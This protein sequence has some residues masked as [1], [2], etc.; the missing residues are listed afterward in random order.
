VNE[1]FILHW[2]PTRRPEFEAQNP[3][4]RRLTQEV[5][6]VAWITGGDQAMEMVARVAAMQMQMQMQMA[7]ARGGGQHQY[8]P[9]GPAQQQMSMMTQQPG[10]YPYYANPYA[11]GGAG[12]AGAPPM[13]GSAPMYGSQQGAP[14]MYGSQP[15][16]PPQQQQMYYAQQPGGALQVPPQYAS[17][18]PPYMAN[19]QVAPMPPGGPGAAS[20]PGMDNNNPSSAPS[21]S[22]GIGAA[23]PTTDAG[24]NYGD[25][26]T[27][28][29]PAA[30]S[31]GFSAAGAEGSMATGS[32]SAPTK[33]ASW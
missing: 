21:P 22:G 14:A 10:T 27:T 8:P 4:R 5:P 15:G 23:G 1:T 30:S 6:T 26:N 16:Y 32:G 19:G 20:A 13:Q 7:Q 11:P 29:A 17:A 24:L 33:Q 25:T 12:A 31:G 18:P 2:D 3:T 9:S 28:A